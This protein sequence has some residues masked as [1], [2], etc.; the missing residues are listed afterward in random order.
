MLSNGR[1]RYNNDLVDDIDITKS[2]TIDSFGNVYVTG[3]QLRTFQNEDYAV[4]KYNSSGT[5]QWV[6]RYN[7]PSDSY[8]ISTDIIT[9]ISECLCYWIQIMTLSF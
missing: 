6:A 7:G 3:I 9:D 2:M 5:K 8:D 4:V 1:Q